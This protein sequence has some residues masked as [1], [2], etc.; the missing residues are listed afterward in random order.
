MAKYTVYSK[1]T[2]I[3]CKKAK[4]FLEK[5]KTDFEEVDI[6]KN[7]PPKKLLEA[8]IDPNNVKA[9]LNT[10]SAIY[11]A[12]NLG[13]KTPDKKAAIELMLKDGNLIKRPLIVDAKGKTYL[14]FEPES[15]KKFL[16]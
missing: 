9:S 2:C 4:A 15:L 11:K 14:G 8:A 7:P 1:S 16:K 5:S 13:A 6:V 3:T 10:R 12:K